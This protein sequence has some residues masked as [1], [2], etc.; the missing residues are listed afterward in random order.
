MT[1]KAEVL[2]TVVQ[3]TMPNSRQQ[4]WMR[5]STECINNIA[6]VIVETWLSRILVG[7][8]TRHIYTQHVTVLSKQ[9]ISAL[10]TRTEAIFQIIVSKALSHPG[11]ASCLRRGNLL[12]LLQQQ[13]LI[14]A[15]VCAPVKKLVKDFDEAEQKEFDSKTMIDTLQTLVETKKRRG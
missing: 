12:T 1:S 15:F 14:E 4:L 2:P 6:R 8:T 5:H 13:E 7:H 3:P 10:D 11:I 9:E